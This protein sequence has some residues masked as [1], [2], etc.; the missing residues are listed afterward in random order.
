MVGSQRDHSVRFIM[1]SSQNVKLKRL[2]FKCVFIK[3][4]RII[5]IYTSKHDEKHL[6]LGTFVEQNINIRLIGSGTLF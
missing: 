4:Q 2:A 3:K 1:L 5:R 6:S